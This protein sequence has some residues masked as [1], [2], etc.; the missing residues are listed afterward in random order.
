MRENPLKDQ[1]P[2]SLTYAGD[3]F[4]RYSESTTDMANVQLFA[5]QAADK[6]SDVHLQA[7]PTQAEMLHKKFKEKKAEQQDTNKESILAKYG[8]E[9]HL[10]APARELLLAQT[11]NY[12]EY[13][14]S[15]KVLK[16]QEPA[17]AKSKYQEDVLINN[18][19][20]VWGSFWSD[21]QWGFKCCRSFLKGS[22][23]TGAAG[24]AAQEA[25]ASLLSTK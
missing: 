1:D 19:T 12:V 20:T 21:G 2:H 17:K 3:N 16:G 22:Y 6:G 5:W 10:D 9:E 23:C 25:S 13:T 8:G 14:R 15:G 7:N 24:I 11:E 18:H 4:Q